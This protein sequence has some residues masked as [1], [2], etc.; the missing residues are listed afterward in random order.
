MQPVA[1]FG[2]LCYDRIRKNTQEAIAVKKLRWG[3]IGAGG[4]ADRRTIPG[5]MLA[6]NAE[7]TAVMEINMDFAERLRA[8]YGAKRAYD[9]EEALLRDPEVDAVY[10]ATPIALH[11]A[12]ARL[13]ARFGKHI[14][15][16]KPLAMTAEE[17][18]A[19]VAFCA[20]Q[21][22]Q[23]AAGFMMRFGSHVMQMKQAAAEGRLGSIVSGY[24]Q[25]TVW[26]PYA[27]GNWR[28]EKAKAG[29][30]AMTDLAVHCIDLCEYVT[31]MRAVR[32]ASMN[33]TL[34]FRVPGY[35]VEDTST[36][37]MRM[38]NGAQFVVQSNF[39]IP[40]EAAKWRLELFG[41]KG[42]L[43]GDNVIGQLD[44]G[45]LNAVFLGANS[46]YD[47]QQDHGDASGFDI[48]GDFGNLY[49]REIESFSDSILNGTPLAVP[50]SDAVHVQRVMEAAYRSGESGTFVNI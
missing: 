24:A 5:M 13:A 26:L 50:A 28:Q 36:I 42:R 44:G 7:L 27:P 15:I 33:E 11:A 39:N 8:K 35:D 48:P 43:M 1:F 46:A 40:D 2:M 16:E 21:N 41:T 31:G 20:A 17:G 29:G 14:L 30:G 47:A 4:I 10:I 49:T 38:E 6:K 22:V 12:Q 18:Q 32:V 34:T 3:V 37:L 45:T 19:V 9:S 23:I 25:F